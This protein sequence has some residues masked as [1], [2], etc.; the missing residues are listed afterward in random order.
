MHE[1]VNFHDVSHRTEEDIIEKLSL[2]AQQR[3]ELEEQTRSQSSSD[4]W[5][6]A[7][8]QRL[9]G[10]ICGRVLNQKAKTVQLLRY[11][12][13]PKPMVYLLK[14]IAWGVNNESKACHAYVQHMQ[15]NGHAGL[16]VKK[17]GFV[18]HPEKGW[19]GAS[20]D[21]WV[22]DPSTDPKYGIAEFKCPYVKANVTVEEACEDKN[23]Y[24]TMIDSKLHLEKNHSYY[25]QVQLQ[26][27]V[28]NDRCNW[29]DFCVYTTHGV[30]VEGLILI[31]SSM[32]AL[33]L[34]VTSLNTCYPSWYIHNTNQVITCNRWLIIHVYY[35][36]CFIVLPVDQTTY[37][38]CTV[39]VNKKQQVQYS[40]G[41]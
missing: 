16:Q 15:T 11:C 10:S 23:F 35:Y 7:C 24:C 29:C 40:V 34:I 28:A 38:A 14:P 31:G 6:K 39:N 41:V 27:Y 33:S 20:P 37:Y 13:Y 30:A 19:L 22:T 1:E 17:A 18:V 5:F 36:C 9:T 4:Q 3:I 21:A 8:R 25:H 26:L 12:V 32:S 2:S